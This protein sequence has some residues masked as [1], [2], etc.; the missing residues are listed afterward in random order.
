MT[1]IEQALADLTP[2]VAKQAAQLSESTYD[3]S[4]SARVSHCILS[5]ADEEIT[6]NIDKVKPSIEALSAKGDEPE[7]V[8]EKKA[9][10]RSSNSN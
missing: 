10:S 4:S 8:E 7:L 2:Q 5:K 3:E 9:K 6:V 1:D